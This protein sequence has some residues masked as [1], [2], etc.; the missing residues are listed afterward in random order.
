[1]KIHVISLAL[2]DVFLTAVH[3]TPWAQKNLEHI[4]TQTLVMDQK[5][6]EDTQDWIH[7]LKT[8]WI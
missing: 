6:L 3:K 5:W 7:C 2:H 8:A 1:M 4:P